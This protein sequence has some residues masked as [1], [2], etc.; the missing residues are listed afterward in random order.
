MVNM[1]LNMRLILMVFLVTLLTACESEPVAPVINRAPQASKPT[2]TPAKSPAA[3]SPNKPIAKEW[4]PDNYIVKKGDK[5]YRIGLEFGFDYREIAAANNIPEPYYLKIGQ[6]LDFSSLK[7]K[8]S[9]ALDPNKTPIENDGVVISPMKTEPAVID[10]KPSVTAANTTEKPNLTEPKAQREPYSVAAWKRANSSRPEILPIETKPTQSTAPENKPTDA[11]SP[12]NKA[13]DTKPSEVKPSEV[14]P[15]EVKTSE[16]EAISWVMPTAGKI[17]GRF[18]EASNKGVDVAGK[19]GQTIVAAS[20]G[21]VIYSGSDLRGYGKL[22]IIKHNKTYL[23]VY[24]H[25]SKILVKD[26]D[27]VTAGQK[28]AEMGNTDTNSVKLHFEIRRLGK[29]VDPAPYLN[30][31]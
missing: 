17:S 27:I 31:N 18:N 12:D 10:G 19:L 26:R 22:V 8:P 20:S 9:T 28:I 24:A 11:K 6:K 1:F 2:V 3:N 25:N 5:L 14:K 21:K 7:T 16:D 30:Q 23:S 15:N 29:S 4:R 13:G